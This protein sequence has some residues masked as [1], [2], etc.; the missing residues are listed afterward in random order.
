MELS[1]SPTP[2]LIAELIQTFLDK[3]E[4]NA[5]PPA[6]PFAIPLPVYASLTL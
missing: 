5:T 1:Y 4:D 6:S 2:N 3:A